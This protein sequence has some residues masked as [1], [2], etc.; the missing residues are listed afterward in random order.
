MA[1]TRIN[2]ELEDADRLDRKLIALMSRK[3]RQTPHAAAR[4]RLVSVL[5]T[6]L[7]LTL[8]VLVEPELWRLWLLVG[9]SVALSVLFLHD[10]ILL[11]FGRHTYSEAAY[12]E[13]ERRQKHYAHSVYLSGAYAHEMRPLVSTMRKLSA[14]LAR[15][16]QPGVSGTEQAQA[17]DGEAEL[18]ESMLE[19]LTVL[20]RPMTSLVTCEVHPAAQLAE[21]VMSLE[22]LARALEVTVS[23]APGDAGPI[24]CDQ[25]KMS[26]ALGHLLRQ[27][28][29]VSP[30]GGTVR[31]CTGYIR[32][33][34]ARFII[35]DEG[36]GPPSD[37]PGRLVGS[38]AITATTKEWLRLA[39]ARAIAEQHGGS[40]VL[41]E[42][43]GGGCKTVLTFPARPDW[44]S[45]RDGASC[46][47]RPDHNSGTLEDTPLVCR[48]AHWRKSEGVSFLTIIPRSFSLPFP[49]AP[50]PRD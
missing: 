47:S 3:V 12:Q 25:E 17:M 23:A 35:E 9:T 13:A 27:A 5:A 20:T 37:V 41:E 11:W 4:I 34:A 6:A 32:E 7:V 26:L 28:I 46:P 8:L 10:L 29:E 2:D 43:L 36:T 1:G 24:V 14:V 18:L 45:L 33:G 30:V 48:G 39:V 50:R 38:G 40:L 15:R 21:S 22:G 49:G 31:A 16:Q 19:G 44:G 42:R